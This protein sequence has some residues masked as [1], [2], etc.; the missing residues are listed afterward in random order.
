MPS[1]VKRIK[2]D[3][4]LE[5]TVKALQYKRDSTTELWEMI[6]KFHKEQFPYMIKMAT[7]ALTHPIHTADCEWTFSYQNRITTPVRN[8][9]NPET[10]NMLMQ[11]MIN[12]PDIKLFDFNQAILV[13][14]KAKTRMIFAKPKKL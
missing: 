8:R 10:T 7:Y 2:L 4:K 5:P 11:I 13:W 9:L 12:G 6:V 14:N 3:P 1:K